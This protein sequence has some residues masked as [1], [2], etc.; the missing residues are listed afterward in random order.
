MVHIKL[1]VLC[2]DHPVHSH[3][4]LWVLPSQKLILP[5]MKVEVSMAIAE[6]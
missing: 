4:V 6:L 2:A 3:P 1:Q 5:L